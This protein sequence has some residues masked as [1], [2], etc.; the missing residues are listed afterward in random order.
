MNRTKNDDCLRPGVLT[1]AL[2]NL[3][4]LTSIKIHRTDHS[5]IWFHG[6]LHFRVAVAAPILFLL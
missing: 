6:D 5:N 4:S 3:H 1:S 2:T